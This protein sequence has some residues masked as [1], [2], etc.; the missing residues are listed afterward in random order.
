MIMGNRSNICLQDYTNGQKGEIYLYSHWDGEDLPIILKRA[1]IK[2]RDRWNDEPYLARIIF[3]EMIKDDVD[4]TTGYGLSSYL[5][6]NEHNII[7]VNMTDNI[8]TIESSVMSFED[9]IKLNDG[10]LQSMM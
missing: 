2:G 10:L 9:Y 7:Y 1:L 4:G 8:V 6:D 5:T 3:S